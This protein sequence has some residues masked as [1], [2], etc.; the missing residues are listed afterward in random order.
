MAGDSSN[1]FTE[2]ESALMLASQ[3]GHGVAYALLDAG[4]DVDATRENDGVTALMLA[5]AVAY[6]LCDY[7]MLDAL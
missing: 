7:F 6:K 4:I 5:A 1:A 3:N 2:R